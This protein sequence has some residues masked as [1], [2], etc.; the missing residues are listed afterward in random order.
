MKRLIKI[1][2]TLFCLGKQSAFPM[3]FRVFTFRKRDFNG[4]KLSDFRQLYHSANELDRLFSERDLGNLQLNSIF[5]D[6]KRNSYQNRIDLERPV[7]SVVSEPE[8]CFSSNLLSLW[9]WYFDGVGSSVSG[10]KLKPIVCQE[11]RR[12]ALIRVIN[13]LSEALNS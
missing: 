9:T 13:G 11:K 3:S 4:L 1:G 10:K 2:N 12:K 8:S 5:W 7:R 6:S